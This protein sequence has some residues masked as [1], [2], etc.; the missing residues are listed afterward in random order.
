M[1]YVRVSIS[2]ADVW[3]FGFDQVAQW[4]KKYIPIKIKDMILKQ[5]KYE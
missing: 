1:A 2:I 4:K 3:A 5:V